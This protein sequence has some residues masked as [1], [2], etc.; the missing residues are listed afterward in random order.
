M[1]SSVLKS[2]NPGL[3]INKVRADFPVLQRTVHGKPL[4][5][6]EVLP[7]M[8]ESAGTNIKSLVKRK[9]VIP[10]PFLLCPPSERMMLHLW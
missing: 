7:S 4:V 8:E 3:D 2:E 9:I 6:S 5:W 10:S 1:S